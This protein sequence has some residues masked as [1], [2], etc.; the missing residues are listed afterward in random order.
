MATTLELV[1]LYLVAAVAGVVGCRLLRLP[2]MLGYLAVGVV[3]GPNALALARDSAGV[4]YL[5]EFG[6][7]FLMFVIGLEFNL[8]KLRT[9]RRLVFGLGL[10][11]VLLTI[12]GAV[13]GNVL[14]AALFR[15]L[16]QPWDLHWQ[17]AVVLGG[18]IAMS[19]TAI[20]VKLMAER[21][22]LESE[23]GRHVMGVLLFQDLAVVPLLVLI[24]ALN[25]SGQ[26]LARAMGLAVLKAG[27]L[28]T[29]L[30]VGGQ[31]V[32]RWWLTIVARR[33]SEELFVL[34]LL[35]VTLGLAWLTEHAGLSLALGAFVA[36]MLIAETEFKHQVETDIRPF[37]DVLLGLFFITIGMKLDWRPVLDHW[38][39]VL[40]LSVLPVAAKAVLVAGLALAFRA[41]Q[42]VAIR[43][44]L[45]LAQA[46]EFGFVLLTLGT[47]QG[48]VTGVWMSPVLAS[49]VISMMATPF[50]ILASN[51]IVMTLSA[52]EW[53]MQS[54]QITAIARKAIRTEAHVI[55]AGYGRSG[56]NLA[57]MLAQEAIPYMALDL[58]PDRV[59]R[60][61][62]AGQSVVFGDAARLP[63]LMAAGLARASAVVVSYHDTPS[64]L[65]ILA[66][67]RDH[68]PSV[69][70]IVRTIDD[71]D[72]EK[73]REAGATEVVPEAIEGSLMLAAQALALVGVPMRRV[74]RLMRDARDKRYHLLRG[75]FHGADDDTVEE[76]AQARLASV[77][78]PLAA[79]SLGQPLID[80]ALHAMGV[81]VLSVRLASGRVVRADDQMLLAAG[82]TLVLSGL[83]EPLALAEA[84]LL[85]G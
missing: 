77:T 6:V 60:A 17:G 9:M 14:L 53:L 21:L 68:A 70:V 4:K 52:N 26:D 12:A 19:S 49:M 33:K 64:A 69:P 2:P 85:R 79:A 55:I 1:L 46:G 32:M 84:K 16:G 13:A 81:Q 41:P 61:A 44:G 27:A 10:A 38:L 15:W 42:G 57:R 20:V 76:L 71:A 59:R 51:R 36:G 58:D 5:A 22:E 30:L 65:K 62:A 18:A 80:Q 7:V 66:L 29:L 72:L 83:P 63:S 43:T 45:Y 73:L 34:N 47:A 31:R 56:Q 67:V 78:L 35:L 54:V 75:Y 3:I 25:D 74:I 11:Q 8:P 24:P 40:V 48:V 28:L 37:H 23:H 82:D 50:I 39:L